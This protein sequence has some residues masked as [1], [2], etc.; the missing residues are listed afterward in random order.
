VAKCDD[1]GTDAVGSNR[2]DDVGDWLAF[3]A[4][5][6]GNELVVEGF[7]DAGQGSDDGIEAESFRE[8][9]VT[10]ACEGVAA[11][12]GRREEDGGTA[13]DLGYEFDEVK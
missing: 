11:S 3:N 6:L 2:L 13:D 5:V 9:E 7:S 10:K 8:Q 1:A 4:E 12:D